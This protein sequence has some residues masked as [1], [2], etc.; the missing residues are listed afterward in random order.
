[1]QLKKALA[2]ACGMAMAFALISVG[3]MK[4]NP[5]LASISL[6]LCVVMVMS[7]LAVLVLGILLP[8]KEEIFEEPSP[9]SRR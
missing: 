6:M 2:I 8:G 5:K 7:A 3:L 1:V 4:T 9:R